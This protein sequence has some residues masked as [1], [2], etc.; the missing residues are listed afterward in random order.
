MD[1]SPV[2]VKYPH[3]R[4]LHGFVKSFVEE[5]WAAFP[6]AVIPAQAGIQWLKVLGDRCLCRDDGK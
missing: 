2:R 1:L 6:L 4:R 5:S 3:S